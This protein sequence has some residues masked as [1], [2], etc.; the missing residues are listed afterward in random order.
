MIIKTFI[1]QRKKESENI[2]FRLRDGRKVDLHHKSEIITV[3]SEFDNKSGK[4]ILPKSR[5][6]DTDTLRLLKLDDLIKERV[7]FIQNWY[8]DQSNKE[9]LTSDMLEETIERYL[10]PEKYIVAESIPVHE[11]LLSH[12]S[13]FISIAPQRKDKKTG[14]LLNFN[15]LQQYKATQKHLLKFAEIE[16]KSDYQFSEI[17]SDF[18][19]RFVAYLQ[20]EIIAT[21]AKGKP[22]LNVDG[23]NKL[24]KEKFTQNSV[25]KHIKVLKIILKEAPEV[26]V[27][28]FYVFTED[29][30]NVYLNETELKTLKDFNFS[31]MPHLDR[32]RDWFLL[33]AWTGSRFSDL[34]KIGKSDIKDN[35]ITFRQQKTNTKVT[36]PL[37]PVVLD[38]FKK[39]DFNMPEAISNQ[40][41]NEYIKEVC[42]LAKIDT[43]E[44]ITR[45][46]GGKLI[47]ECK[48]KYELI[49]SHTCRR[50]FCTNMYKR[51][52][53]TLMIMSISGHKTEK[54][55]LK[56]IKVKQDEHAALM[57]ERWKEMYE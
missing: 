50:C 6:K 27:S 44:L 30:D 11:T 17:N 14:R 25:G 1:R 48:P 41:F 9:N 8:I 52:L 57:A 36:I 26:D 19:N 4:V 5:I 29:I 38:I 21:D 51:D 32:V 46:I 24:L 28:S 49:S 55:F 7:K 31:T 45:T 2:I 10:Y 23:T 16:R 33:L 54:S 47:T 20:K 35:F 40:R 53:P 34:D 43:N 13:Y 56:Y 18:Y 12:I 39:Y 22:V 37:H 15:N 42:K 3:P